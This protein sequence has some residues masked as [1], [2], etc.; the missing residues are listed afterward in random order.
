MLWCFPLYCGTIFKS[1][2]GREPLPNLQGRSSSLSLDRLIYMGIAYL[3][4][5]GYGYLEGEI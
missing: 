5:K 3:T 4:G 2:S 1:V